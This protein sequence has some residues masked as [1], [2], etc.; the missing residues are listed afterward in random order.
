MGLKIRPQKLEDEKNKSQKKIK[1]H[2]EAA[3]GKGSK[4][5]DNEDAKQK[6]K[7]AP[8]SL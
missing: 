4:K 7:R 5:K 1:N 8:E 6:P 3:R 2:F